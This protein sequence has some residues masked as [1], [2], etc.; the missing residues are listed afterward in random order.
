MLVWS[1]LWPG[2]KEAGLRVLSNNHLGSHQGTVDVFTSCLDM[3]CQPWVN[4]LLGH[5]KKGGYHFSN[6]LAA[7][8][9][10][11]FPIWK[12]G[13]P[14]FFVGGLTLGIIQWCL[15]Q[16]GW[17]QG[18]VPCCYALGV[19]GGADF[20]KSRGD[21]LPGCRE[22]AEVPAFDKLSR[23]FGQEFGFS[24]NMVVAMLR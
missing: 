1:C 21:L 11:P 12:T 23:R 3:Q 4:H 14:W 6:H 13:K 24:S 2:P 19:L 17:V 7:D 10:N 5:L 18:L 9:T 20:R 8:Q 22:H 16:G 15:M